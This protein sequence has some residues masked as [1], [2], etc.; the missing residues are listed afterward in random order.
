MYLETVTKFMKFHLTEAEE[1]NV[2][3]CDSMIWQTQ[4]HRQRHMKDKIVTWIWPSKDIFKVEPSICEL[5]EHTLAE[6]WSD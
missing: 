6:V 2:F 1:T 4:E 5:T 3:D